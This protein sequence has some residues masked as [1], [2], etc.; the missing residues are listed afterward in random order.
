MK[1]RAR[2]RT[3]PTVCVYVARL[4]CAFAEA[5]PVQIVSRA[6]GRIERRAHATLALLAGNQTA[7][8][9]RVRVKEWGE[10]QV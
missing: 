10:E 2:R 3:I 1:E 4:F 7:G 8:M 6:R 5:T 9:T